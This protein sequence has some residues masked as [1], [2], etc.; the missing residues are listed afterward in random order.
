MMKTKNLHLHNPVQNTP[1]KPSH[2]H[3]SNNPE[4]YMVV[5]R[6][7]DLRVFIGACTLSIW[8]MMA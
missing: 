5:D 2:K 3:Q 4:E 1:N 7:W 6:L 8:V